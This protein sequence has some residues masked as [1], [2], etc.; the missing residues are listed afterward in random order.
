[1]NRTVSK[2]AEELPFKLSD[3]KEIIGEDQFN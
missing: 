3:L 2:L 1:E